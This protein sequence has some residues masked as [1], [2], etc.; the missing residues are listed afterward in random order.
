MKYILSA[1]L[2]VL[3]CLGV[4]IADSSEIN[5]EQLRYRRTGGEIIKQGSYLGK[6]LFVNTQSRLAEKEIKEVCNEIASNLNVRVEFVNSTVEEPTKLLT[7]YKA[8]V[9]IVIV[10]ESQSPTLLIAAEDHWAIINTA[11]L[12]DDLPGENA[13]KKFFTSRARKMIIKGFSLL[14]GGG[15]SQFPGNIMNTATI[16]ELDMVKEQIPVDMIDFWTRYL[17]RIGVTPLEM[18]T[19]RKACREG[20][21]PAPTNDIQKAI[22]DKVHAMPSAPIKIKPETKKVRE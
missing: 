17:G 11:K 21:A 18:T 9:A 13:K 1:G 10:D 19:Y 7:K 16:R 15:S 3:S 6:I 2:A 5:K 20:W 14:C 12:V 8:N 4:A 22:W